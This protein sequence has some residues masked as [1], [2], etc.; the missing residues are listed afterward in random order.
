MQSVLAVIP[1]GQHFIS[2]LLRPG[3]RGTIG[4][5]KKRSADGPSWLARIFQF[6]KGIRCER[7]FLPTNYYPIVDALPLSP[8]KKLKITAT[9][10]KK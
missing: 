3:L 6:K 1:G 5:Q 7:V 10:C 9:G 8:V 2:K 4:F